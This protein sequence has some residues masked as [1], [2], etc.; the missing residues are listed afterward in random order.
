M[1]LRV[2]FLLALLAAGCRREDEEPIPPSN[3]APE[4]GVDLSRMERTESG[5]YIQT[6]TEGTGDPPPRGLR[7]GIQYKGWLVDGTPFDSTTPGL[8][9]RVTIGEDFM[10]DGF[11]EGVEGI[12]MGEERLLVVKPDLGYGRDLVPDVPPGSWLVFRLKRVPPDRRPA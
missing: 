1:R 7:I 3:F 2:L 11:M 10:V 12:R 8:P 9:Q 4:L 6:L 5:L